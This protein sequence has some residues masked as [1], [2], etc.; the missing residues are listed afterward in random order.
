MNKYAVKIDPTL[1][2]EV[3]QRYDALNIPP[4]KGF[5]N[6]IYTPVYNKQGNITD[7]TL[8]YTEG[9]I[10]QMLRYSRDYSPLTK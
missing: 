2:K 6:P 1:H 4:Y 5:V 8:D 3:R 9:Y 7:V 10:D